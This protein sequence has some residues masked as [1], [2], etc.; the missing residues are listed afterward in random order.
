[1]AELRESAEQFAKD[2]TSMNVAGL[3]LVFT[4]EGMNRALLLQTQLQ[5]SGPQ[6]PATGYEVRVGEDD[7]ED[8]PVDVA[9]QNEDGEVVVKTQWRQVDGAWKVNDLQLKDA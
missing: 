6:K 2:L 7:G 1:M 9:L 5:A 3:M 8:T 4:P